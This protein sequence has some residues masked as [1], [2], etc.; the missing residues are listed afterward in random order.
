M[1]SYKFSADEST[2]SEQEDSR[3]C[4]EGYVGKDMIYTTEPLPFIQSLDDGKLVINPKAREMLSQIEKPLV[5]IS[6]A[7]LYRTGKSFLMNRLFGQS[8]FSIGG[9]TEANTKGIWVWCRDHPCNEEQCLVVLDSEGLGDTEKE[10]GINQDVHVFALA[11]LLS[12]CVVYNSW[13][14]IDE[15]AIQNLSLVTQMIEFIQLSRNEGDGASTD[16]DTTDD[17]FSPF[18]IW[19]VRDFSLSLNIDHRPCTA[20]EYLEHALKDKPG[21][22]NLQRNEV[23]KK[24]REFFSTRRCFTLK[25]P[26]VDEEKLSNLD[27]LPED[28]FRPAFL[29]EIQSFIK[30]AHSSSPIKVV[31]Q[32]EITGHHFNYLAESYVTSLN[33]GSTPS[34][35]SIINHIVEAE[36]IREKERITNYYQLKMNERLVKPMSVE[37]L[38]KLSAELRDEAMKRFKKHKV[39]QK[40]SNT[41]EM[42]Q[43]L[44]GALDELRVHYER[45]NKR[46]SKEFC[47]DLIK[48]LYDP[49]N[50]KLNNEDYNIYGG[51]KAFLRDLVR[52]E[53]AYQ[54]TPDRGPMSD[55]VLGEFV[56]SL[57]G[58]K[59]LIRSGVEMIN[60]ELERG[61]EQRDKYT[62]L[63]PWLKDSLAGSVGQFTTLFG[64]AVKTISSQSTS[65]VVAIESSAALPPLPSSKSGR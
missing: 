43:K 28:E 52:L 57:E 40:A 50:R 36:F 60:M 32:V 53:K 59:M 48:E 37:E 30:C 1:N 6:I 10:D 21:A 35:P 14:A 33:N 55:E 65:E 54:G 44:T 25:R 2:I 5:V 18:F 15:N 45:E 34:I 19:V 17:V 26:V 51:Y 8:G 20:D 9:T 56:I 4:P 29:E 3:F 58:V 62:V 22:R 12:S 31:N 23:R 47:S 42:D 13:N 41:N 7:G 27:E 61:L 11:V 39:L 46:I 64:Q 49:I 63:L 24:I 38:E 16:Y